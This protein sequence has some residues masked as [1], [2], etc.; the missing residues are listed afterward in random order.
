M[1]VFCKIVAGERQE[2]PW[3]GSDPKDEYA[4][5]SKW[6]SAHAKEYQA[7]A[8][9]LRGN[10]SRTASARRAHAGRADTLHMRTKHTDATEPL[11]D[12]GYPNRGF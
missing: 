11:R 10:R 6:R 12:Q 1:C 7:F 8:K 5:L 4:E 2:L 9:S 3:P